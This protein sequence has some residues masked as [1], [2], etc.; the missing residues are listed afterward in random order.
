MVAVGGELPAIRI[1][2]ASDRL[3]GYSG[4]GLTAS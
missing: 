3:A 1:G 2:T 4:A